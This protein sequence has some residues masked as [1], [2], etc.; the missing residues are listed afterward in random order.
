MHPTVHLM[1]RELARHHRILAVVGETLQE[2]AVDVV[3][4]HLQVGLRVVV[5]VA[6]GAVGQERPQVGR[7]TVDPLR[8]FLISVG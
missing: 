2:Q 7:Q 8:F 6:L 3:P 1:C 5:G 4:P